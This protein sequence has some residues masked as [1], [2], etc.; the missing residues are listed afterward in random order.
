MEHFSLLDLDNDALNIIGDYVTKDNHDR[1]QKV[2]KKYVKL[3]AKLDTNK[4]L[5][6]NKFNHEEIDEYTIRFEENFM[7]FQ[8]LEELLKN[9]YYDNNKIYINMYI[10]LI[11]ILI[12]V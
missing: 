9:R 12:L 4:E 10:Y 7:H 3:Y 6:I 11:Y 5:E 8:K 2:C 1:I